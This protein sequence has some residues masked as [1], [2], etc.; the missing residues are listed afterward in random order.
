MYLCTGMIGLTPTSFGFYKVLWACHAM[1]TCI[2][3]T[4]VPTRTYI[5]MY[6]S[7][8]K[9]FQHVPEHVTYSYFIIIVTWLLLFT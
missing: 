1:Y 9:I 6:V 3:Y 4:R 5:I 8:G 2:H 7:A